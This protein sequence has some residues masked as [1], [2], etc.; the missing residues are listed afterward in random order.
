VG[1]WNSQ[2][3]LVCGVLKY[4]CEFMELS[5]RFVKLL[6]LWSFNYIC[7]FMDLS[8]K[9]GMPSSREGQQNNKFPSGTQDVGPCPLPRQKCLTSAPLHLKILTPLPPP[10]PRT[11]LIIVSPGGSRMSFVLQIFAP[12]SVGSNRPKDPCGK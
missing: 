11:S 12:S 1:L 8:S 6:S 10:P 2:V 3:H 7:E 4:I 9:H 5:S